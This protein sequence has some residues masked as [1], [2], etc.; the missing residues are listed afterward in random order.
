[1]FEDAGTWWSVVKKTGSSL[2]GAMCGAVLTY[3][4]VWENRDLLVLSV[5]ILFALALLLVGYT[6]Y[7]FKKPADRTASADF[8]R[9]CVRDAL[10][11]LFNTILFATATFKLGL[12]IYAY[13]ST[14]DDSFY[15]TLD[16]AIQRQISFYNP[17][18]QG[19]WTVLFASVIYLL[20]NS[21]V[22]YITADSEKKAKELKSGSAK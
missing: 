22:N 19:L 10:K 21:I 13:K 8:F 5:A 20:F 7:L 1:M 11:T 17:L 6:V 15:P 2:L 3:F 18:E 9:Y 4:L 12:C 14:A 16:E